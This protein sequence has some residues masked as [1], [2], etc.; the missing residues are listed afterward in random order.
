MDYGSGGLWIM[1]AVLLW[2][3]IA[4]ITDPKFGDYGG[5]YQ[6]DVKTTMEHEASAE[7][8]SQAIVWF[9]QNE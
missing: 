1:L 3:I 6:F 7:A 5:A 9:N 8:T 2:F 4:V